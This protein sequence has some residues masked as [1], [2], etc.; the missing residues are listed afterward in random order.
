MY[1]LIGREGETE[2]SSPAILG[3][4]IMNGV[5]C[6]RCLFLSPSIGVC[7]LPRPAR[8]CFVAATIYEAVA[9]RL[10]SGALYFF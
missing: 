10:G 3:V 9:H 4:L 6:G 5:V 1:V 7:L 8:A 2:V